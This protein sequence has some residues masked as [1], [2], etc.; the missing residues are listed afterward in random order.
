M[1]AKVSTFE[2]IIP[3][4]KVRK[5]VR[6]SGRKPPSQELSGQKMP[7]YYAL[8]RYLRRFCTALLSQ[9]RTSLVIRV[10]VTCCVAYAYTKVHKNRGMS[11]SDKP[12]TFRANI[13]KIIDLLQ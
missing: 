2:G 12:R 9:R 5:A 13:H 4:V 11:Y 6:F 10:S 7:L 3:N 1:N 8:W